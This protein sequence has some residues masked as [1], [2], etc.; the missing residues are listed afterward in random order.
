MKSLTTDDVSRQHLLI[1]LI[2]TDEETSFYTT[3]ILNVLNY[4][5]YAA[6]ISCN[7]FHLHDSFFSY[8]D[9]RTHLRCVEITT[10]DTLKLF[11][12]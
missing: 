10:M 4:F 8:Y 2:M 6:L 11:P 7:V 9:T 5:S 3:V 12:G 1:F